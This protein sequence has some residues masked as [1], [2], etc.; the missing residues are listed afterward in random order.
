MTTVVVT[1]ELKVRLHD[2]GV[3][4]FLHSGMATL[5]LDSVFEPPCSLKWMQVLGRCSLDAFSYAVSGHYNN[6]TFGRYVSIGEEVSIGRGNHPVH[7][8][9]TAPFFY[10]NEKVFATGGNFPGAQEY[11]S[12]RPDT[13]SYNGFRAGAETIIENDVWI[14][15]RAYI[16]PGVRISTGAIVGA[17]AVV[18]KDVPPY[19]IVVGNPGRVVKTRFAPELI[20][21]L[22]ESRWWT[23]APWQLTGID[24]SRPAASID[25]IEK[26]VANTPRFEPGKVCLSDLV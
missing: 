20:A 7:W 11:N 1:D 18:T 17:E 3:E 26:R 24:L 19:S 22:L 4:C 5:P 2:R 15:H 12:F 21:R 25:E 8:L 16:L 13:T 23:L 14:G 9:S 6:V 10:L